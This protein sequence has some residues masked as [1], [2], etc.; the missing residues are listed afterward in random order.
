MANATIEAMIAGAASAVEPSPW[1]RIWQKKAER[2]QRAKAK[3]VLQRQALVAAKEALADTEKALQPLL[4]QKAALDA[5]EAECERLRI[6]ADNLRS[7]CDRA[8]VDMSAAVSGGDSIAMMEAADSAGKLARLGDEA[9]RLYRTHYIEVEAL[10]DAFDE[11]EFERLVGKADRLRRAASKPDEALA[12]RAE[13]VAL[14]SR[15][16]GQELAAIESGFST[17]FASLM[18]P[19]V[20]AEALRQ[21]Q[22]YTREH[23]E[24]YRSSPPPS[25]ADVVAVG[26]DSVARSYAPMPRA[27]ATKGAGRPRKTEYL[28]TLM[29]GTR[30][31]NAR[32]GK[33]TPTKTPTILN[34]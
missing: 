10:R 22:A 19:V 4:Y 17:F 34:K 28:D 24:P 32:K 27:S 9:D 20:Q 6:I 13:I 11:V 12:W 2:S 30:R 25:L 33:K 3:R 26:F 29:G 1:A 8:G 5:A 15:V 16:A 21:E 23:V 18:Q 14:Q 7:Q 31:K